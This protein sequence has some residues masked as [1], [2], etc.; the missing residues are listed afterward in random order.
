MEAHV[1]IGVL[2]DSAPGSIVALDKSGITVATGKDYLKL[3][4]LQR[5]G[6]RCLSV[7]ELLNGPFA[8]TIYWYAI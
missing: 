6:G 3:T 2:D 5:E 7:A 8:K 1:Q 4:Q